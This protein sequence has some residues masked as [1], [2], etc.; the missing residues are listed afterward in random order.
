[1]EQQ[2]VDIICLQACGIGW[3]RDYV[4]LQK[5]WGWGQSWWAGAE[6]DRDVGVGFLITEG[7][8]G[9]QARGVKTIIEGRLQ[10]GI[11]RV[12]EEEV[13]PW[14]VYAGKVERMAFLKKL[15]ACCGGGRAQN[16]DRGF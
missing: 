16:S 9:F 14:N 13:I 12:G 2:E 4:H 1:M 8:G 11:I 3:G 15:G 5:R 10:R 7:E 6:D